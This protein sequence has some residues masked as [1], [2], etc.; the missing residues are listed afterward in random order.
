MITDSNM[1]KT[2]FILLAGLA[3]LCS[4]EKE[5]VTALAF[6]KIPETDIMES[7]L[8]TTI[9]TCDDITQ[10]T[11][12]F[13]YQLIAIYDCYK[14]GNK[15]YY[16]LN[17]YHE[18]TTNQLYGSTG[19]I[20]SFQ[21]YDFQFDETS[22]SFTGGPF[23]WVHWEGVPNKLLYLSEEY[24]ILQWEAPW[25]AQHSKEKGATFSREVYERLIEY[26]L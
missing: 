11:E 21:L 17:P 19:L 2:A 18:E 24:I 1:K 6:D 5:E 8:G 25:Q 10:I 12:G 4:C 22:Q 16:V 23:G 26:P 20:P 7:Q 14:K 3:L 13:P 15:T 9:Y